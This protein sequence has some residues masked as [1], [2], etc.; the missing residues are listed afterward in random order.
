[1]RCLAVPLF[2][3]FA[4]T[5]CANEP[6]VTREEDFSPH[7]LRIHPIFTQV[8]DFEGDKA[9]DGIEVVVELLD[10]YGEPTRGRGTLLF[11]LWSYR[12]Q[13]ANMLGSRTCEPWR[14]TLLNRAEQDERWSKALRAYSFTLKV[15]KID[16]SKEYVLTASFET[17]GGADKPGGIRLY[18]RLV[19]EPPPDKKAPDKGVKKANSGKKGGSV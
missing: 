14:A 19:I 10:N 9:P 13:N 1:M 4:A 8:K 16:Q 15:P 6:Q 2:L 7:K 5:G 3:L 12:K 18:D 11:E 17:A